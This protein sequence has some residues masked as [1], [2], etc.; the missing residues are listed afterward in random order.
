MLNKR[1][2]AIP[3]GIRKPNAAITNTAIMLTRPNKAFETDLPVI[4][5][6]NCDG[7]AITSSNV[8]C[9]FSNSMAKPDEYN[10]LPHMPIIPPPKTAY[11]PNGPVDPWKSVNATAVKMKGAIMF[12]ITH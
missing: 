1:G 11:S 4:T 2:F 6:I 5:C 12:G 10:V 3:S 9:H 8:P 7:V